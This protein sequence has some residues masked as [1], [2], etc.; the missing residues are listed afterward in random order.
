MK[1]MQKWLLVVFCVALGLCSL[2]ACNGNDHTH[3]FTEIGSDETNHWKYCKQDNVKD[4]ASV[5]AHKDEDKNGK[6]DVCGHDVEV[7]APVVKYGTLNGTVS[8]AKRGDTAAS[9]D[10]VTVNVIGSDG[11]AKVKD[12]TLDKTTGAYAMQCPVGE[13]TLKVRKDGYR[14]V[15]YG[16]EIAEDETVTM[17]VTLEYI[18]FAEYDIFGWEQGRV[19]QY[20]DGKATVTALGSTIMHPSTE[21]F[22]E[23]AFTSYLKKSNTNEVQGAFVRFGEKY[24]GVIIKPNGSIEWNCDTWEVRGKNNITH[25]TWNGFGA[26]EWFMC[27]SDGNTMYQNGAN[28][29]DEEKSMFEE[30]TLPLTLVRKG[31]NVYA[32]V[33]GKY[34]GVRNVE[35]KLGA[36]VANG[37]VTAGLTCYGS[38]ANV[39]VFTYLIETDISA[40]LEKCEG[41]STFKYV[42]NGEHVTVTGKT[43]SYKLNDVAEI[44]LSLEEGY[45]ITSFKVNGQDVEI[46]TSF[47]KWI[48][49]KNLADV[50]IDIV[51]AEYHP[52]TINY[53]VKGVKPG[54]AQGGEV[55]LPDGKIKLENAIFQYEL[56]L[57]EGKLSSTVAEGT[58]T[59]TYDGYQPAT[60][61]VDEDVNKQIMLQRINFAEYDIFGWEQGRVEQYADG[62]AT[63]TALGSTVMHPSIDLFD[64]VAF[65]SYLKKSNTNELQGAFVR[66]GEKYVWVIIKSN[67]GSIEW[68]CDGWE[69]RG[70]NNIS[71][72]TYNHFAASEWFMCDSDGN[73]TYQNGT[74]LTDEE[75]SMFEEGTLPLTLVRKGANVYV[76]INGKYI[77]VRNVE[78]HLGSEIANGKVT[79]GLSCNGSKENA[80]VFTYLVET[81][82]SAYLEKCEGDST[83]KYVVTGEHVTVTGKTEGFKVNDIAEIMLSVEEGYT[84]TSFKVN[85]QDAEPKMSFK[86][87]ILDKNLADVT[88]EI[89]AA[90]YSP[91]TI[92]YTVKGV[93]PGYAQGGEVALPDGKIKLENANF[94]YE[95]DLVEGKLSGTVA[96]G[97]YT[98]TYNGYMSAKV[99]VDKALNKQITLYRINFAEHDVFGWNQGRT[100]QYTDGK[101]TLTSL[102]STVMHPSIDLFDE[103]AFTS[104]LKKSNTGEVQG[105]FVRFGEKFIW[106][107]IKP[108]GSIEWNC[109]GWEPRGKNNISQQTYNH[110]AASEWWM[111]D[112][113]GNTTYQNGTN[114]TDEEKAMFEAGTLPLTL[115]RKGANVY[116]FINGKY[117]GVRNVEA[118]LGSEIANGKVTVG[119]SC[120]GSKENASVFT[121]LVETDI[122]KYLEKCEGDSTFKYVVTGEHVTITGKTE[123]FKVN[124]IAEIT[125]AAE[126][127]Y[128][129]TSVKV[130]GVETDARTFKKWLLGKDIADVTIEVITTANE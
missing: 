11:E 34:I 130:D 54:Y 68:N 26:S 100:E 105:A 110:F 2:L 98:V 60:V 63:V 117:I 16:I 70:K 83:F 62:K 49:D 8:L 37:K 87:W 102:G 119:L 7:P 21:L 79:V 80:S 76:F 32:F 47:K 128:T 57:V 20:A 71:Q 91:V 106:V 81:D 44:T 121:Y 65:T 89:V 53:T 51:T 48:L 33:N 103:V 13:Y 99:T 10:G 42:V 28:L 114:L 27:D 118:H 25:L 124:D 111:C 115:V 82:I 90:E 73:T 29:T 5:E 55:A 61:T 88:I 127:G 50:T 23:V 12:F 94:Q 15:E 19:E 58:Y 9:G 64:E 77:G 85:G 101:A 84:I 31:A 3:S 93:K 39:S 36:E 4:P 86:K 14:A 38:V 109:D 122:S 112:S 59:V 104:Y 69:P 17:N 40:Y 41:D 120:N 125:I 129:I 46:K 108:N 45:T 75:K 66:F 22:D 116:V 126:E 30:G 74:N 18:N 72:Q 52:V 35:E 43:E 97:I 107:I 1:K 96:E 92:D 56:D 123:G 95:L 6:C 24:I 113:D 67:N 78:A